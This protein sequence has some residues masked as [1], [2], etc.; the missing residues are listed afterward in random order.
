MIDFTECEINKFKYYGGKNGGKLCIRYD[1][2]DYML[3]FPAVNDNTQSYTNSCISE[4]ITCHIIETLG[5]EVQKTLLGTYKKNDKE[6][7]VVA[8]KDFT[9]N[10][11]V[12]KQFAELK[13]SQIDTSKNGYGTELSEVI[14][15]IESQTIYDNLFKELKKLITRDRK[16]IKTNMVHYLFV[17]SIKNYKI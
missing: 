7:I 1:S 3:K 12:L 16:E 15:T 6:K 10:G 4:Y 17:N 8:C 11:T 5:L 9:S 14:E 13:N 2:E